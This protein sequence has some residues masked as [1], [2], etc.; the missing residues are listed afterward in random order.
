MEARRTSE[1]TGQGSA[2]PGWL[3]ALGAVAIAAHGGALLYA[4]AIGIANFHRIGV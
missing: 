2:P 1:R 3:R 4:V